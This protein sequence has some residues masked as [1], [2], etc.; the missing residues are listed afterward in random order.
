MADK[1]ATIVLRVSAELKA[2]IT[3]AA[4]Q[5]GVP[6]TTFIADSAL[7][8]AL[9]LQ[10]GNA[11]GPQALPVPAEFRALCN[12]AVRGAANGYA[13]PGWHLASLV[14]AQYGPG[15]D[16]E[17]WSRQVDALKALLANRDD[18]GTW[19]WFQQHYPHCM[20]LVP[21][22]RREQFLYGVRRA[23]EQDLINA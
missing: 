20:A 22:R 4:E 19:A 23:Y 5:L 15:M 6:L 2:T 8:R 9:Q 17:T 3:A 13:T 10:H 12:E 21:S 7:K 1:E 16:G 11:T 14:G 18:E